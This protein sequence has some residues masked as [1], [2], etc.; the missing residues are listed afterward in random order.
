MKIPQKK[1]WLRNKVSRKKTVFWT[2][3]FELV[4]A[5]VKVSVEIML[6]K[7]S[8]LFIIAKQVLSEK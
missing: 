6:K 5:T 1:I 8:G 2:N 3:N 7:F 4:F